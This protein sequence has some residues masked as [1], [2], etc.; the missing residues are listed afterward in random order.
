MLSRQPDC[1]AVFQVVF[2]EQTYLAE[3]LERNQSK[4]NSTSVKYKNNKIIY[5]AVHIVFLNNFSIY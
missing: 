5:A 3:L 1:T 4:I 2:L